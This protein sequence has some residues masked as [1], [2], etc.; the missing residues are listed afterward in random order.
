MAKQYLKVAK[1]LN[2]FANF[3]ILGYIP[4]LVMLI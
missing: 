1:P 3:Y 4:V 2:K